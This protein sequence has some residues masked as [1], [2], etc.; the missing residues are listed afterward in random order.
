M[1]DFIHFTYGKRNIKVMH[2]FLRLLG[3]FNYFHISEN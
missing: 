2:L 3:H 1:L